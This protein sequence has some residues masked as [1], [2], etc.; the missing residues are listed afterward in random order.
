MAPAL[1]APLA[2]IEH[3][4]DLIS[5]GLDAGGRMVGLLCDQGNGDRAVVFLP[6][7]RAR[8]LILALTEAVG[9]IEE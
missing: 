2:E 7:A 4:G 5:V 9:R 6:E 3:E 8:R 1:P